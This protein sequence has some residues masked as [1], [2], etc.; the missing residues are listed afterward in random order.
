MQKPQR[1]LRIAACGAVALIA[2]ASL[3]AQTFAPARFYQHSYNISAGG[4]G[5]YNT[6]STPRPTIPFT[7]ARPDG[8]ATGT[9]ELRYPDTLPDGIVQTR[10]GE[11]STYLVLSSPIT[12]SFRIEF[13]YVAYAPTPAEDIGV[14][15]HVEISSEHSRGENSPCKVDRPL[16][17]VRSGT[18]T[19]FTEDFQCT[20]SRV[21]ITVFQGEGSILISNYFDFVTF[22]RACICGFLSQVYANYRSTSPLDLT[23][24]RIEV[25]QATQDVDNS[26]RL[27]AEKKTVARVF[28][29]LGNETSV[30]NPP[31]VRAVLR[32]RNA[33]GAE[34]PGSPLSA[35][36]A[37]IR[38][39]NRPN[40]E[41]TNDSLNF[42]LPPEWTAEGTI[43]LRAEVNADGSVPETDRTNNVREQQ[44]VF[45]HRSDF[46]VRWVRICY[47]EPSDPFPRCPSGFVSLH[48]EK[49][50]KTFPVAD[51]RLSY[52]EL[53][54]P[55]WTWPYDMARSDTWSYLAASLRLRYELT[56]RGAFDQLVGWLPDLVPLTDG[57][58]GYSDP[59]WLG[60]EQTGRATWVMDLRGPRYPGVSENLLA[61]EIGHNLGLRHTNTADCGNCQDDATDWPDPTSGR[62]HEV[63][64]DPA[65]LLAVSPSKFDVMTY[66]NNPGPKIW[67]SP[68]HFNKLFDG[69]FQPM[70]EA[71]PQSVVDTR[72]AIVSGSAR[73]DG[74]VG[75]LDPIIVV[76][77]SAA[78]EPSLAD[79]NY[80]VRFAGAT[81]TPSDYCFELT[82][83]THRGD[84]ELE[85]E[86]FVLR[87][88][89]P[90]G[91][92]RV[93][94][95]RGETELAVRASSANAP[96]VSITSP[97][98]GETWDGARTL[99]WQGSDPDGD[100]L[101]YSVLYS[102]DGGATW[103][104]I[105]VNTAATELR[106]DTAEIGS[107]S[108]VLFRVLASDGFR[109]AEATV[110][111]IT[112]VAAPII[113]VQERADLGS[114]KLG[115]FAETT[116]SIANR[117]EKA[118]TVTAIRST[119]GD[120]VLGD[121]APV[122]VPPDGARTVT[123]RFRPAAEGF[124]S[125][126]ISFES[127]DPARPVVRTTV[128]GAGVPDPQIAATP[129]A[130]DFG[131][132]AVGG[133]RELAVRFRNTGHGTLTVLALGTASSQFVVLP[134]EA[135][136]SIPEGAEAIINLSFRPAAVGSQTSTLSL[137]STAGVSA[138]LA[139]PISGR[140]TGAAAGCPIL[141]SPAGFSLPLEGGT[142][143]LAVGAP[144]G[145]SWTARSNAEWVTVASGAVGMGNGSISLTLGPNSGTARSAVL[146]VG[147][148]AVPIVQAGG[149]DFLVVPAVA[150]TPGALGSHFKTGLQLHNPSG[151]AVTGKLIFHESGTSGTGDDPFSV[152]ELAPGQTVAFADL[153]PELLESGLGSLDLLPRL[154]SAPI[155]TVRVFNDAGDAGTTGMTEELVRT[156]EALEAGKRGVLIAPP[157][158]SRAR[159]NMG[160]RSLSFGATVR[161]TVRDA[162]GAV[163]TTGAKFYPPSFFAQQT[164]E[165][166][167]GIALLANDTIS[168]EVDAGSAIVYGATTDNTTQDPSL[169]FARALSTR[170]D[171]RRTIAAVAAAPGVLDSLF[172]TTLQLHNP[173]AAPISGRL[174]FHPGGFSGTDSDPSLPYALAPGATTSYADILGALGR[175]GLGSLDI[176]ATTGSAPLAVARVFNDGGVRGTTGFSVDAARPEDALQSGETGVLIAPADPATTRFNVG[177]R[178]FDAGASLSVTVRNRDGQSIRTFTRIYAPNYF[179]QQ[180]GTVFLGAAPGPSDSV[181]ITVDAG[182]AIVYGA[183][184]DNKTQDPA[185]QVARAVR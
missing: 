139:V 165:G 68:F 15:S 118:L 38:A 99:R 94:L 119:L 107:G 117:G 93:A 151:T 31:Q 121:P 115:G 13:D 71:A 114:V 59:R 18:T 156:G 177:I 148:A 184:T 40:R 24:S 150:S 180:G 60:R 78:P 116:L 69:R 54:V 20:L 167:L 142:H 53:D 130:L 11:S 85:E 141:L 170:S 172:R 146:A 91:A 169:Q 19:H 160:V 86:Y 144:P 73:R 101:A 75:R 36:N 10:P 153:L 74:S 17:N 88:P 44:A 70:A 82:F 30:L 81:G 21:A 87:I 126:A 23:V 163:R 127:D 132:V 111:P 113:E 124:R 79:G 178:T 174:V 137:V 149:D 89:F 98:A 103:L 43:T 128:V 175:T 29:G 51:A 50:R 27:V 25:V 9:I 185:M 155:A 145:C 134:P 108:Q 67:I 65:A 55:T 123:L 136:L 162:T 164:A 135:P 76:T 125:A 35:A 61:H 133:S 166:F 48:D 6:V 182:S 77:S 129:T 1:L 120:F 154:G 52:S 158:P 12:V 57:V 102:A 140:G 104:P 46:A 152:Y 176:V 62:I 47:A 33:A 109:I 45:F 179:E 122:V 26:I 96:A 147:D 34:L 106:F 183:S 171:P 181:S 80:C 32:G 90:D 41:A 159:F 72:Y 110:G 143:S 4:F 161:F 138:L 173:T 28:V 39:P 16:G 56:S 92:T 37:P 49:M 22:S 83:H 42:V 66:R 7:V 168:F 100:A 112:V 157:E 63:G 8:T 58:A 105:E 5:G 131:D 97:A 64:F 84:R 2:A 14:G 95:R 3:S